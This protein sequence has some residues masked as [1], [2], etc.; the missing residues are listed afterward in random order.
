MVES[1]KGARGL[2][3]RYNFAGTLNKCLVEDLIELNSGKNQLNEY[4]ELNGFITDAFA[5]FKSEKLMLQ[6]KFDNMKVLG[7][8]KRYLNALLSIMKECQGS[9]NIQ[10]S[11]AEE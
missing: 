8:R 1:A 5:I 10:I 2:L 7:N 3:L 4:F 6:A 11:T 9:I